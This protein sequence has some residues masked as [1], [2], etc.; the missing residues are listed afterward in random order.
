MQSVESHPAPHKAFAQ[1]FDL[2]SPP[3]EENTINPVKTDLVEGF[4]VQELR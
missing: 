2:S 4:G 3:E 1:I